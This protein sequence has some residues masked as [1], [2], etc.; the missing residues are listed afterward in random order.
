MPST[1][2][3]ASSGHSNSY[4]PAVGP[5]ANGGTW[6]SALRSKKPSDGTPKRSGPPSFAKLRKTPSPSRR[7]PPPPRRLSS[8]VGSSTAGSTLSDDASSVAGLDAAEEALRAAEAEYE[9][10]RRDQRSLAAARRGGRREERVRRSSRTRS[11]SSNGGMQ[12]LPSLEP[13]DRHRQRAST[14][15]SVGYDDGAELE[16]EPEQEP[17]S[18]PEYDDEGSEPAE[19]GSE[20]EIAE[21]V[22]AVPEHE[23]ESSDDEREGN[24]KRFLTQ[25]R[26][27]HYSKKLSALGAA[28]TDD[29]FELGPEELEEV[30][31][32]KLERTRLARFLQRYVLARPRLQQ[33]GREVPDSLF[34][35]LAAGQKPL[36]LLHGWLSRT[37]Q[38]RQRLALTEWRWKVRAERLSKDLEQ[39]T[40]AETAATQ[41]RALLR[42]SFDKAAAALGASPSQAVDALARLAAT[43]EIGSSGAAAQAVGSL[44][45]QLQVDHWEAEE[46]E[47]AAAVAENAAAA[48]ALPLPEVA[49]ALRPT[50][51]ETT[52]KQQQAEAA[53]TQ[54]RPTMS[55][56]EFTAERIVALLGL[57]AEPL[58]DKLRH[59]A[60]A[61]L[62]HHRSYVNEVATLFKLCGGS[63]ECE[64]VE[65]GEG[66]GEG[67]VG[68]IDER[69]FQ[70]MLAAQLER[71]FAICES[72]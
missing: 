35:A 48:L 56:G 66:E 46:V 24:L 44:T 71:S 41:S 6:S 4:A 47:A 17:E 57:A 33:E 52:A 11:R 31:M 14:P 64:Q 50:H 25:A 63:V 1:Y 18:D 36:R 9:A 7:A 43:G 62:H 16:P 8:E 15:S 30:G 60:L 61:Y 40:A 10:A 49:D 72:L 29:L 68:S 38:L 27:G 45:S 69:R 23:D 58:R 53:A 2:A 34:G 70:E 5:G 54:L 28:T 12:R 67:A 20:D 51:V 55:V 42:S 26:L 37:A 22:V 39:A 13:D 65:V 19:P 21:E 59:C 32:R 3:P